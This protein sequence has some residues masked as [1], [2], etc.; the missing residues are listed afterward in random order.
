MLPLF[1]N[2]LGWPRGGRHSEPAGRPVPIIAGADGKKPARPGRLP[3]FLT[4]TCVTKPGAE[5][6]SD[7][8]LFEN[9][10]PDALR[11]PQRLDPLVEVLNTGRTV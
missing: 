9:H 10:R 8:T 2:R 3:F 7:E 4:V 1:L 11:R 6:I 5:P